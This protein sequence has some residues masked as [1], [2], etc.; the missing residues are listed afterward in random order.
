MIGSGLTLVT[1]ALGIRIMMTRVVLYDEVWS[2]RDHFGA[3]TRAG[4]MSRLWTS[5][6]ISGPATWPL[7]GSS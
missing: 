1:I 2:A 7:S 3:D 4:K 6:E 5:T